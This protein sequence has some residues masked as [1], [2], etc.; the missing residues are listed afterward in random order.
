VVSTFGLK[1][2]AIQGGLRDLVL[3]LSGDGVVNQVSGE[4]LEDWGVRQGAGVHVSWCC[5]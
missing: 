4:G 2:E 5:G 1:I 3:T